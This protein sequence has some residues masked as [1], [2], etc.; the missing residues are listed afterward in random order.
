M[1]FNVLCTKCNK[2]VNLEEY[3]CPHCER[4]VNIKQL[5]ISRHGSKLTGLEME[6]LKIY[7]MLSVINGFEINFINYYM[8]DVLE[9]LLKDY[10]MNT[11]SYGV[12]SF[13]KDK[14][15][16]NIRGTHFVYKRPPKHQDYY[17]DFCTVLGELFSKIT[18]SLIVDVKG[19]GLKN[20]IEVSNKSYHQIVKEA[21]NEEQRYRDKFESERIFAE[22]LARSNAK[23]D[24]HYL[25]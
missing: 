24:A 8:Y 11:L 19:Y 25:D 16:V 2:A 13:I 21:E 3:V 23:W 20:E 9:E 22:N 5:K 1:S 7:F 17:F 18:G 12:L 6:A 15:L 4:T 10:D 14:N